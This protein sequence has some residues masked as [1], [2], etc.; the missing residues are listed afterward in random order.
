MIQ[1]IL[2]P[3]LRFLEQMLRGEENLDR[4]EKVLDYQKAFTETLKRSSTKSSLFNLPIRSID[5][6]I[7]LLYL[8]CYMYKCETL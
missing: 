4:E 7:H 6:S 1:K 8:Y 3:A 5:N 2:K